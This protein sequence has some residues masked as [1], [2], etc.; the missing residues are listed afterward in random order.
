MTVSILGREYDIVEKSR[1]NDRVLLEKDIDGYCDKSIARVVVCDMKT[2]E[3]DSLCDLERHKKKVMRHEL[4]HAFLFESGL[5]Q[6]CFWSCEEMI[7]W[8]ACQFPKMSK[9]F[10]EAGCM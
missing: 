7:D 2:R 5:E 3:V 8:L 1:A 4:I 9:A 6:E 10:D